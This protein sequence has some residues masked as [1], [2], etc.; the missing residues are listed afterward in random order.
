MTTRPGIPL[1]SYFSASL[2]AAILFA[3]GCISGGLG[4]G[5]SLSMDTRGQVGLMLEGKF[6]V[7]FNNGRRRGVVI[8]L[9]LGFGLFGAPAIRFTYGLA[10]HDFKS[11][12]ALGWRLGPKVQATITFR[13]KPRVEYIGFGLALALMPIM[14]SKIKKLGGEKSLITRGLSFHTLGLE[15]SG[16]GLSLRAGRCNQ[17]A[18][19]R[20]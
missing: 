19:W 16:Y 14:E 8:G 6:H 15:I 17:R 12:S 10:F 7:G 4:G 1:C 2:L 3:P 11:T 9:D 13:D 5:I 20:R 18:T